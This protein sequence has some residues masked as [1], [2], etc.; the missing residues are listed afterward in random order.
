MW[1]GVWC[2]GVWCGA[3][4][5]GQRTLSTLSCVGPC[6]AAGEKYETRLG[7]VLETITLPAVL[8]FSCHILTF[9]WL[10]SDLSES[11]A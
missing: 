9:G 10:T 3:V 11:S 6:P 8:E 4:G 2:G 5:P 1:G 7:V